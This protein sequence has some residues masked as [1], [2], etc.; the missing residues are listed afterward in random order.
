MSEEQKEEVKRET[1][2]EAER[3]MKEH[4]EASK[5]AHLA[6]SRATRGEGVFKSLPS[7]VVE[8]LRKFEITMHEVIQC[9]DFQGRVN[10]LTAW[11]IRMMNV[12]FLCLF[13]NQVQVVVGYF[14]IG[15]SASSLVG[16]IYGMVKRRGAEENVAE[17][18][19]KGDWPD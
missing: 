13:D 4:V 18:A 7:P 10:R 15:E 14:E 16:L 6:M 11:V 2:Q 9:V 1:V 3:I 12:E 5:Q 8:D 19:M 17:L